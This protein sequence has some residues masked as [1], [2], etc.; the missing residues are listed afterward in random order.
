MGGQHILHYSSPTMEYGQQQLS[1]NQW[2]PSWPPVP[3]SSVVNYSSIRYSPCSAVSHISSSSTNTLT[4]SVA[5][6]NLDLNIEMAK[7][8]WSG[9]SKSLRRSL[10]RLAPSLYY[11][12]HM[13]RSN[14]TSRRISLSLLSAIPY[15]RCT[16]C[17]RPHDRRIYSF[18]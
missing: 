9:T 3:E 8:A 14:S 11:S 13:R 18:T 6:E 15:H 7:S 5:P 2:S 4:S 1:L 17:S 10:V 16:L 12:L